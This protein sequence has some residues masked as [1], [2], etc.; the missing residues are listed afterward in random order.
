MD[1]VEQRRAFFVNHLDAARYPWLA[2][3]HA[4]AALAAPLLVSGQVFGAIT[5]LKTA[6]DGGFD[7]DDV[8]KVTILVSPARHRTRSPAPEPAFA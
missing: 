1:A 3:C 5:F 8:V 6:P 7:D 2:S 4:H